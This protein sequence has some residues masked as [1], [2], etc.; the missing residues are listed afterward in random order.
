MSTSA[1]T[2]KTTTHIGLD[3]ETPSA[4]PVESRPMEAAKVIASQRI[5]GLHHRYGWSTAA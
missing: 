2:T 3:K 1:I 4:R 5:G